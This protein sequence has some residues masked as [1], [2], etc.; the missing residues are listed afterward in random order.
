MRINADDVETFV[1]GILQSPTSKPVVLE[2]F[3][4]RQWTLT[5][6]LVCGHNSRD[7]RCSIL[8]HLLQ[9]AFRAHLLKHMNDGE[10]AKG[11]V[12]LNQEEPT[13]RWPDRS[14]AGG[15][16]VGLTSHIGGHAWAGNVIAYFSPGYR[17][18]NGELSPLSPLADKGVWYGRVQPKHV[19]GIMNEIVKHGRVIEEL[20]SGVHSGTEPNNV[21]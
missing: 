3:G 14:D 21:V 15:A 6:I 5:T 4:L 2:R 13:Y 8:G 17:L 16:D 12:S 11:A 20:L 9:D 10:V 19:E 18:P 7:K 1:E